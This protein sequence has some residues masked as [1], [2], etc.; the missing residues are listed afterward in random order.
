MHWQKVKKY[1]IMKTLVKEQLYE[2]LK[3]EGHDYQ[4]LD[5]QGKQI[6]VSAEG[7][8]GEHHVFISWED[9]KDLLQKFNK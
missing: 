6:F 3:I 5:M 1:T 4:I 2:H 7:I 9:I 8:L